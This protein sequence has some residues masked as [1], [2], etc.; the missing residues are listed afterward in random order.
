VNPAAQHNETQVTVGLWT[1]TYQ[2]PRDFSVPRDL[3]L[4]LDSIVADR[5]ALACRS[6]LEQSLNPADPSVWRVRD[7]TLNFSLDTGFSDVHGVACDWGRSLAFE[8]L[9]IVEGGQVNDS[10]LR[11][12][13][14]AAFLAQF[15]ADLA[16]GRAWGKWYYEEFSDLQMLPS[17]QVICSIFLR[18]DP[19]PADLLRQIASI[20]RLET[21]LQVLNESDA[22]LIFDLC[23][24]NAASTFR[25]EN[26]QKWAGIVLELWNSA[27]LRAASRAEVQSRD[28]LRLLIRTIS[29]HS[30][31]PSDLDLKRV[32]NGLLAVRSV[33]LEIRKPSLMDSL[34][35][36]LAVFDLRS[37]VDTAF[38][39]GAHDP[40][41]ALVLFSQMMQGDVAWAS[42]AA[43]VVLGES[44]KERFLTCKSA[45]EGE[46]VLSSFGG[47]FLLGHSL[48]GSALE[49]STRC[50]SCASESPEKT[51][52]ILR[53]LAA[54]KCFGCARFADTSDDPALRL[55]SG[56]EGFS[57]LQALNDLDVRQLHLAG[58][59]AVLLQALLDRHESHAPVLFADVISS[60]TENSVLLLRELV[61]D[62]WLDAFPVSDRQE[63]VSQLLRFSLQRFSAISKLDQPLVILGDSLSSRI[64]MSSLRQVLHVDALNRIDEVTKEKLAMELGL[65]VPQLTLRLDSPQEH[66]PYLSLA[67]NSSGFHPNSE[68]DCFF[69]LVSR[70]ALR[71][72]SRKLFGF[73]SSSPEHIFHNFLSGVSEIRRIG[74][75]L[76]VRLPQSPLSMI[77]RMAGLQNQKYAP[78][79]LKGLEVWLLPP[80]E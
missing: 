74:E 73:E 34:F 71:L 62:E 68:L 69:T 43:A 38:A 2:L 75:H 18:K 24:E 31:G 7:L 65:S 17:R 30:A 12:P 77:L 42:Q 3:Q 45:A 5:L 11:F 78:S 53:H 64:E 48:I 79:W 6:F 14:R 39:A 36:Q 29:R 51:V 60:S 13:N 55:F 28:A 9:S 76:E 67:T 54:I 8:I 41:E 25:N 19:L 40:G 66:F 23:F 22:G 72:F 44:N 35:K 47:I 57:F 59:H 70:A 10:I 27:P 21:V 50:A 33:L 26:L 52:A 80:Q 46:S 1:G 16:A 15:L 58:A 63:D 49:E 32:I 37:A 61:R 20:G 56:M 4:R